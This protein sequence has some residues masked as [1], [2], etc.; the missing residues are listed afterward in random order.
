[1]ILHVGN[2]RKIDAVVPQLHFDY[3]GHKEDGHPLQ[4]ACFL[5]G[6]DT[7]PG[8]T[9]SHNSAGLQEDGHTL[10]GCWNSRMGA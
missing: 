1:M 5:L 10:R 7:S 2:S 3:D 8:A 9:Y 4:I 6:T